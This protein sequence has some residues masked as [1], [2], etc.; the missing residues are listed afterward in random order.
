M[1]VGM[2]AWSPFLPGDAAA[3]NTPAAVF[4]FRVRNRRGSP[5]Q[6]ALAF[7]FPGMSQQEVGYGG[8][9]TRNAVHVK[10]EGGFSGIVV[11]RQKASG[12]VKRP[13]YALGVIEEKRVRIGGGLDGTGSWW[14]NI[15]REL[16]FMP[17]RS[18][19]RVSAASVAVDF[20][21]GAREERIVRFVLAW[22]VDGWFGNGLPFD[23]ASS[24]CGRADGP[25]AGYH[26]YANR[27]AER[28]DDALAVAGYLTEN[29]G[30]LLSRITKWQ[31]VVYDW[32]EYPNWLKDALVNFL[33]LV[34]ED[35]RWASVREPVGEWAGSEGLFA[36]SECPRQNPQMECIVCT[37]Y[38]H[39]PIVLLFPKLALSTARVF[40]QFQRESGQPPFNAGGLFEIANPSLYE[41]Q[42]DQNGTVYASIVDRIWRYTGDDEVL[43]EFYESVKK[44]TIYTALLNSGPHGLLSTSGANFFEVRWPGLVTYVAGMRLAGFRIVQRMAEH[45][46]D[47]AFAAQCRQWIE[48]G[49]QMLEE[50]LWN[51]DSYLLYSTPSDMVAESEQSYRVLGLKNSSSKDA[52]GAMRRCDYVLANQLNGQWLCLFHGVSGVFPEGRV[53]KTLETIKRLNVAYADNGVINVLDTDG[54]PVD[55]Y[56]ASS[57]FPSE[58]YIL[59]ATYLYRGQREVG[60]EIARK[61][62]RNIVL[63]QRYTWNMPNSINVTSGTVDYGKD[64]YQSLMLWALPIAMEGGTAADAA[65]P[66]GFVDSILRAAKGA[67]E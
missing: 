7:T 28:F 31:G 66:G 6:C 13:G 32:P 38:G 35:S 49:G 19:E 29:H 45:M 39:W 65:R 1:S 15:H 43:R 23:E 50:L 52:P 64:Y 36:M 21:L 62:V 54:R 22:Y 57:Y 56:R 46:Q 12:V 48:Q 11:Q 9:M 61:C 42:K 17:F 55:M 10:D 53:R 58:L 41:Y 18:D 47:E 59:A 51:G 20:E 24:I 37:W 27:Y 44:A 3:S 5:K 8:P 16:P 60:L 30:R 4:E 14:A 40:K 26:W 34:A 63:E 2:R 33:Y 67:D 25:G